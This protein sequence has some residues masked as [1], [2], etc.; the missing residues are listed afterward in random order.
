MHS[1]SWNDNPCS[2]IQDVVAWVRI[3]CRMI[4]IVMKRRET[5]CRPAC[6]MPAEETSLRRIDGVIALAVAAPTHR[7]HIKTSLSYSGHTVG[8]AGKGQV[9]DNGR[10]VIGP[11]IDMMTSHKKPGTV[12]PD[13]VQLR[14]R[15]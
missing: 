2:A 10:H 3:G 9:V 5:H 12:P 15:V 7:R 8:S 4:A 11:L 13:A 6:L 14:K 1:F